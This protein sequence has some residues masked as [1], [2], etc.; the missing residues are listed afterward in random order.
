VQLTDSCSYVFRLLVTDIFREIITSC[1]CRT[2]ASYKSVCIGRPSSHRLVFPVFLCLQASALTFPKVQAATASFSC[3][4]SD[5]SSSKLTTVSLK[6]KPNQFSKIPWTFFQATA[7]NIPASSFSHHSH[8]KGERAKPRMSLS[9]RAFT[10][11]SPT[12]PLHLMSLSLSLSL[13]LVLQSG[14]GTGF[15]SSSSL[16]PSISFHQFFQTRLHLRDVAPTRRTNGRSLG[17]FRKAMLFR[18]FGNIRQDSTV[19][20]SDGQTVAARRLPSV[21]DTKYILSAPKERET[22]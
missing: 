14:T 12:L 1:F 6:S 15:Y 21:V 19:T 10:L 5:L 8:D 3:S 20:L 18:K 7:F 4:P 13:S 11:S 2:A 17:T 16:L 22:I 9:S